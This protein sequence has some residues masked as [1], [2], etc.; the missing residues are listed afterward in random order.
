MFC[1][2]KRKI[3]DNLKVVGDKLSLTNNNEIV[4]SYLYSCFP[5]PSDID[6]HENCYF[7]CTVTN[8]IMMIEN[9]LVEIL[10]YIDET[11]YL[12]F[13]DLKV[14]NLHWSKDEILRGYVIRNNKKVWLCDSL[15]GGDSICKLDVLYKDVV[16]QDVYQEL[17]VVYHF[18]DYESKPFG[19]IMPNYINELCDDINKYIG[20]LKIIKVLKRLWLLSKYYAVRNSV[21]AQMVLLFISFLFYFGGINWFR[22]LKE[23]YQLNKKTP[24]YHIVRI[25]C[26]EIIRYSFILTLWKY[27]ST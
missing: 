18:Y 26:I 11:K 13:S 14:N 2:H 3:S 20:E 16:Y 1:L 17:T 12:K 7:D 10:K 21:F 25:I 6:M 8:A 9:K 5:Y 24:H 23:V 15:M 4:G 19:H 27:V 22:Y